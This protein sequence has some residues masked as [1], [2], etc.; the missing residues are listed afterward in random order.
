MWDNNSCAYDTVIT[1]LYN[2]WLASP[3]YWTEAFNAIGSEYLQLLKVQFEAVSKGVMTL[4]IARNNFRDLLASKHC[5]LF[6]DGNFASVDQII[7][8]VFEGLYVVMTSH[9]E[10]PH[11]HVVG[12][13]MTSYNSYISIGGVMAE[14]GMVSVSDIINSCTTESMHECPMC[15]FQQIHLYSIVTAPPLLIVDTSMYAVEITKT[16]TLQVNNVEHRYKLYAAVYFGL[17]H[18]TCIVLDAYNQIWYHDGLRIGRSLINLGF[19][20]D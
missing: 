10:C 12:Q 11:Q 1:I 16:L 18:F 2:L 5:Q 4:D 20:T 15:G 3:R 14:Y 19:L 9:I 7:T 8:Y 6:R 17:N 13:T